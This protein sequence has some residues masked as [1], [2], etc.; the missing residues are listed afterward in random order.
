MIIHKPVRV[1]V[2]G[3]RDSWGYGSWAS[4]YDYPT[5]GLNSVVTTPACGGVQYPRIQGVDVQY[6]VEH[7]Y[8]PEQ[9]W[10]QYDPFYVL[11]DGRTLKAV[12][13]DGD[14]CFVEL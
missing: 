3:K 13:I 2:S 8:A 9:K 5:L 7:G 12:D 11:P 14:R 4:R 1:G 10:G 6:A